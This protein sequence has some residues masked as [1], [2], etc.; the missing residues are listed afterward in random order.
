LQCC[1]WSIL[2]KI[3][4]LCRHPRR[5]RRLAKRVPPV[6][7]MTHVSSTRKAPAAAPQ[8]MGIWMAMPSRARRRRAPEPAVGRLLILR[9]SMQG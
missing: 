5:P 7:T 2:I 8:R 9:A 6:T 3:L 4:N 1:F